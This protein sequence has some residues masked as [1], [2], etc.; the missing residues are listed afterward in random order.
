VAKPLYAVTVLT[1]RGSG[2]AQQVPEGSNGGEGS[3]LAAEEAA[4]EIPGAVVDA[5]VPA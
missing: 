5:G 4:G 3:D 2:P 1:A